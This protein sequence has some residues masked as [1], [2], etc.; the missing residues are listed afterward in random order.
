MAKRSV[1]EEAESRIW[2]DDM[3]RVFLSHKTDSKEETFKVKRELKKY[4]IACFVA[5][6]DIKP[7]T[8]WIE[9]IQN[10]L[11]T[12]DAFVALMTEDF[13]DSDWTDQEVGYAVARGVPMIAARLGTDPY[14]FI[15]EFQGLNCTWDNAPLR[16]GKLL[17]GKRQ[18]RMLDAYMKALKDCGSFNRGNELAGLLSG[19][20]SM[21]EAR[22]DELVAAYNGNGELKGSYGFNGD[23]PGYFGPGLVHYLN[24]WSDREFK[25]TD[26]GNIRERK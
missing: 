3:Y 16:I 12:M 23:R 15:G 7:T 14:G 6:A 20:E 26:Q 11:A 17:I 1:S 18:R 25:F 24:E 19:I 8:R 4:G 13:H 21:N 22:I 9:E 5:H 10:A 2:P